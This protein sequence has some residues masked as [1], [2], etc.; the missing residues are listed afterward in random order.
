V[1]TAT[2]PLNWVSTGFCVTHRGGTEEAAA[3]YPGF[4]NLTAEGGGRRD[5]GLASRVSSF[6]RGFGGSPGAFT[7]GRSGLGFELET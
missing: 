1:T 5:F 3:M 2:L 7:E 4:G 6:A